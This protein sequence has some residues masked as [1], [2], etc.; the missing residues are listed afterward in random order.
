VY[1]RVVVVVV[2]EPDGVDSVVVELSFVTVAVSAL[3]AVPANKKAAAASRAALC[4][5][6]ECFIVAP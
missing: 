2:V 5:A 6:L 1:V 4:D 3:T